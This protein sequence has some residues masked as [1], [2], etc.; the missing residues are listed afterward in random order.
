MVCDLD[1]LNAAVRETAAR[2]EGA[3]LDE[4]KPPEFDAFTVEVF[5]RWAH[6][7]LT[8]AVRLAGGEVLDIRVWESD[9]EFGGYRAPVS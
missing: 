4:V 8:E 2:I 3:D 6:G 1:V 5:A 7:A 9:H